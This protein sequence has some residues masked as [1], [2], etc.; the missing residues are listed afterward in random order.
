MEKISFEQA[1]QWIKDN[2]SENRIDEMF[3]TEV[4][5][6]NWIDDTQYEEEGYECENDY[7]TDYGR[8]EAENA[9]I[10]EVFNDLKSVYE[11]DFDMYKEE[12]DLY[13]FMCQEYDTLVNG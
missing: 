8:G 3:D 9:V 1:K 13:K 7:Y 4:S 11:V 6:G 10:V 2:Y 12:T 5:S